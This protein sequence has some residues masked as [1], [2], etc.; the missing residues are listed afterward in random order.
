MAETDST[1]LYAVRVQAGREEA[2][3]DMLV[4]R[5]RRKVKEEGI[6]TGL[7]A[8]IAPEELRGYVIIEVEELTDELRDLIHD[9]PDTRGIVEKPMDFE[10]IEHYFAP[11]PEAVE[12]SEGD[13]VEILSGPFK[14]EKARVVSVDESRREITVEL[15]EAPVPIPVT[16]KMDA[17]RLLREEEYEG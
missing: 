7:K 16:V 2:T 1:K 10:E 9:L 6:E 11:K 17:L 3:A 14:G 12:I 5:A 15:L 13:V 8:V 4:M